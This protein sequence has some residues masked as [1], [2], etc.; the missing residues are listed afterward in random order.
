MIFICAF[1]FIRQLNYL[2]EGRECELLSQSGSHQEKYGALQQDNWDKWNEGTIYRDMGKVLETQQGTVQ[3][4]GSS[5]TGKLVPPTVLQG[6]GKERIRLVW[7]GLWPL[8]R[9]SRVAKKKEITKP[10]YPLPSNLWLPT[11]VSHWPNPTRSQRAKR[12]SSD[13]A[14]APGLRWGNGR[15]RV[16]SGTVGA[17]RK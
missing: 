16:K 3:H 17:N 6:Q 2:L 9:G 5:N 13:R 15:E 4:P 7:Q 10:H 12:I 1:N 14:S 8:V 11:I